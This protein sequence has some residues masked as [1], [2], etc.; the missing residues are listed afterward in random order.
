MIAARIDHP[1]PN[2]GDR[3]CGPV[4]ML[5]IHYTGM[6]TAEDA[7][8][9][10]TDPSAQVS[11]HYL[12]D[13]GGRTY[14]LVPENK[15]AWH[16]GVACWAGERD[17]NSRSVGIELA[18]RGHDLGYHNF[19]EPQMAALIALARDILARHPIPPERVLAHS[20]VAP[21]RKLDPGEK[22]D[23]ACL[24]AA[25][26]GLY[27]P[28]GLPKGDGP[29]DRGLFLAGLGRFGYDLGEG[30]AGADAAVEA[31]RRHFHA[32]ALGGTGIGIGDDARLQWLL[33]RLPPDGNAAAPAGSD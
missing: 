15:R 3:R 22:F 20:D 11:A 8:R 17:V 31:F 16:A 1:S 24:A 21:T 32:H 25:G 18:N 7:L 26:I 33:A 19:P 9:R 23:W 29:P 28:E 2:C 10:L 13:E 5:V 27:P 4:D 12:I 14:A 30:T 6:W